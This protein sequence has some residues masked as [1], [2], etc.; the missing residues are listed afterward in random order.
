MNPSLFLIFT[1][2][3]IPPNCD[4][5]GCQ[6]A[7]NNNID[8]SIHGLWP[9][10]YNNSY[11]SYC[12]NSADFDVN[13]LEPIMDF[14]NEYWPSYE[15]SNQNF[16]KHEYMKHATCY[17]NITEFDFFRDTLNLYVIANTTGFFRDNYNFSTNYNLTQLENSFKGKFHCG[18]SSRIASP[19]YP[20]NRILQYWQC[21]DL[22]RN[23][24]ECPDWLDSGS[25]S[26]T[27]YFQNY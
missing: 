5:Q 11:P 25:C 10:Y 19:Y 17:P 27:V 8:F 18:D 14:L 24:I 23:R 21:F 9:E 12:N 7:H 13:K 22:N 6:N 20:S 3:F 26:P 15:G 1:Q 4:P 16:W 2:F